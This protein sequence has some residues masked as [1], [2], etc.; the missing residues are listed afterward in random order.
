MNTLWMK[1]SIAAIG[2]SLVIGAPAI[3]DPGDRAQRLSDRAERA[4]RIAN[5]VTRR[6]V[7]VLNRLD[8]LDPA[9]VAERLNARGERQLERFDDIG[10]DPDSPVVE[11]AERMASATA[12]DVADRIDTVQANYEALLDYLANTTREERVIDRLEGLD[13]VAVADAISAYG[14]ASLDRLDEL[15]IDTNSLVYQ[16]AAAQAEV[17]AED[18]ELLIQG[19]INNVQVIADLIEDRRAGEGDE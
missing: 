10:F 8:Q 16:R 5:R 11:R 7:F 1:V 17:T 14:E 15:G 4:E 19:R 13:P 18:V 2:G 6:V 3:A 9:Q 12:E